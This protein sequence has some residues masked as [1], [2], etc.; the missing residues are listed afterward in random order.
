[1]ADMKM[2]VAMRKFQMIMTQGRIARFRLNSAARKIQRLTR[3]LKAL[4]KIK[5]TRSWAR[6]VLK[7]W[8]TAVVTYRR[9]VNKNPSVDLIKKFLAN[10]KE[11]ARVIPTMLRFKFKVLCAQRAIKRF[12]L[13]S[14]RVYAENV[15][16]WDRVEYRV[17]KM[18]Y[19][20][21]DKQKRSRSSKSVLQRVPSSSKEALDKIAQCVSELRL[22][23][24]VRL[25]AI[26]TFMKSCRAR[27]VKQRRCDLPFMTLS[28]L[29]LSFMLLLLQV[30]Q[31]ASRVRDGAAALPRPVR[32]ATDPRDAH[33]GV[34]G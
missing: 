4:R 34:H 32:E 6:A 25:D 19:T 3:I 22:P 21:K 27:Y 26:Y 24:E 16:V 29:I 7:C 15:A 31:R 17:I 9:T 14:R 20:Q 18:L 23:D 30:Y 8:L 10:L 1:M 13:R 28:R 11:A 12:L 33:D 2:I 5:G